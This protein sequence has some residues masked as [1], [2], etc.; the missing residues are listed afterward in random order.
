MAIMDSTRILDHRGDPIPTGADLHEALALKELELRQERSNSEWFRERFAEL[1]LALEDTGWTRIS[2]D[3]FSTRE[4][5]RAA[6]RKMMHLSRMMFLK[7]PLIKNG[8]LIQAHYV[9]GQ[10]C[11]FSSANDDV[12]DLITAWLTDR[13]NHMELTGHVA[14]VL[15]EIELKITG[16]I[17][18]ALFVNESTGWTRV[19]SIYQDEIDKIIC[20][21]ENANEPWFYHRIWTEVNPFSSTPSQTKE[22]RAWYPDWRYKYS[23]G[24]VNPGKILNDDVIE[25]EVPICHIK[26]GH[27]PGMKFGVPEVYAAL[28]W[29]RAVK[30]D[31]EDYAT[32]KRA[33]ATFAWKLTTKG[34]KQAVAQGRKK[35]DTTLAAGGGA[36]MEHN[37]PPVKGAMW[38]QAEGAG[39]LT[40]I[41][42]AGMTPSPEDGQ[43]LWLMV[44]AA[45][46]IPETMLSGNADIGNY[47]TSKTLDRPTEL[48]ME[49]RREFWADIYHDLFDFLIDRVVEAPN[50]VLTGTTQEN[51]Y[52]GDPEIVLSPKSGTGT[53]STR[54]ADVSA[55][56]P[57]DETDDGDDPADRTVHI[58]FPPILEHDILE[59]VKSVQIAAALNLLP[60]RTLA[61]VLAVAFGEADM[62]AIMKNID[63]MKAQGLLG[64]N[65]LQPTNGQVPNGNGKNG[66][67][68]DSGANTDQQPSQGQSDITLNTGVVSGEA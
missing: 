50:G 46:G 47:A 28:D 65:L 67:Q 42:T 44:C 64:P 49:N 63:D 48:Q 35:F 66:T 57:E 52:T 27:L 26:A 41:R 2:D 51:K 4:F 36:E 22:K 11:S 37:P 39:D 16:N 1:E 10:G 32:T 15:K 55:T 21:P 29:A 8:P 6:L 13:Q 9:W 7:N 62:D 43:R 59:T 23:P 20:N 56:E 33:L 5:S 17:F 19:A 18:L 58:D 68:G 3:P 61:R 24:Y 60:S 45:M 31:L 12:N 53:V 40:P 54:E 25:N 30:D 14:R 34:G 38:I